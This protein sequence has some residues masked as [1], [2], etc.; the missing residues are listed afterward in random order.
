MFRVSVKNYSGLTIRL[1]KLQ[2][3]EFQYKRL[4]FSLDAA[5]YRM[6]IM[7]GSGKRFGRQ[8]TTNL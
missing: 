6:L 3:I 4:A 5:R 8:H 7:T 2:N 1:E